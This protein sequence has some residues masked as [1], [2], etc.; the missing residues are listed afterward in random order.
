MK[1]LLLAMPLIATACSYGFDPGYSQGYYG[2]GYGG[3]GGPAFVA[4]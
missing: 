1:Y 4:W 2:P 3:W